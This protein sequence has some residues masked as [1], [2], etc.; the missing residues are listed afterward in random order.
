MM[1]RKKAERI[2]EKKGPEY[3]QRESRRIRR[4]RRKYVVKHV[5]K[6]ERSIRRVAK[7]RGRQV[8]VRIETPAYSPPMSRA[9]VAVFK[10]RG[11]HAYTF[12]F[13]IVVNK[14]GKLVCRGHMIV[15][16]GTPEKVSV[17]RRDLYGL[18]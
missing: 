4:E 11:F 1:D 5:R 15:Q 10:R 9:L 3:E 14:R 13:D 2:V 18:V 7:T 16:W 12:G 6:A 17:S 8:E